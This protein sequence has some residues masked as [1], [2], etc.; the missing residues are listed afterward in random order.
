MF[1]I[2]YDAELNSM[3]SCTLFHEHW[4]WNVLVASDLRGRGNETTPLNFV[5]QVE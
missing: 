5:V 1:S 2:A 3:I 4:E